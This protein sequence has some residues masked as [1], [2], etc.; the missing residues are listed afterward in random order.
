VLHYTKEYWECYRYIKNKWIEDLPIK[1]T[2]V[3]ITRFDQDRYR[4]MLKEIAGILSSRKV[5]AKTRSLH[6][7]A[8]LGMLKTRGEI[9]NR[10]EN[11]K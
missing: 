6:P 10:F 1:T 2:C 5:E 7:E 9:G 3:N 4:T 11:R 8:I